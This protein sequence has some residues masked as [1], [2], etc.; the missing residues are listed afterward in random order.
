[1]HFHNSKQPN[2][3]FYF[4]MKW[5]GK[6]IKM[7]EKWLIEWWGIKMKNKKKQKGRG[8]ICIEY[9]YEKKWDKW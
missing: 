4:Y 6:K 7:N 9:Y 1:M 5:W 2:W 3:I 8:R